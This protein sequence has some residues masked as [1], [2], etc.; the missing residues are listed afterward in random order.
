MKLFKTMILAIIFALAGCAAGQFS[1]SPE[2]QI[3]G[4]AN[5][6]TATTTLA[7]VLLRNDKITVAQAKSYR[8]ML[9]AASSALDDAN[10]TL[11]ACRKTTLSTA[12]TPADPCRLGVADVIRLALDSIAGVKRTLDAK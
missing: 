6:L 11:L 10:V 7:T 4:G 5:A 9:G 1:M 2:A 8:V 12:A 3:A